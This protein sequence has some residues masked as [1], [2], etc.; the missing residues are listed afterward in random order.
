M[1]TRLIYYQDLGSIVLN[2]NYHVLLEMSKEFI[3][4]KEI[5]SAHH[6]KANFEIWSLDK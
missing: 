1:M 3:Q 6:L 4:D 5:I 2:V